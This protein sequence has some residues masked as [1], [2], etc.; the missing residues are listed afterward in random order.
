MPDKG[1]S[2]S[3]TTKQRKALARSTYS[4]HALS[5]G[6][7]E[8]AKQFTTPDGTLAFATP[9]KRRALEIRLTVLVMLAVERHW[10]DLREVDRAAVDVLFA[11]TLGPGM[12]ETWQHQRKRVGAVG[13]IPILLRCRDLQYIPEAAMKLNTA[14]TTLSADGLGGQLARDPEA[15]SFV[16]DELERVS[17]ASDPIFR[18]N[19][20]P[21]KDVTWRDIACDLLEGIDRARKA[22]QA[23][24]PASR[25]LP[26][27]LLD[28]EKTAAKPPKPAVS[29][30]EGEPAADPGPADQ[31]KPSHAKGLSRLLANPDVWNALT[32]RQRNSLRALHELGARYADSRRDAKG[33]AAK[34]EGPQ[35]NCD[36]FKQPLADLVHRGLAKSR[37][38][39]K[40]GYWLA[41]RGQKLLASVDSDVI[42]GD[43]SS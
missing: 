14:L 11:L 42:P 17:A 34:A 33:I 30:N 23:L 15:R 18:Q 28:A 22:S 10:T 9:D 40:G 8:W 39:R 1:Q 43:P 7:A 29:E 24:Q 21:E 32:D 35:A 38:G 6:V 27:D 26:A 36:G 13:G 20:P 16:W 5:W 31:F 41:D 2:K 37:I 3:P 4:F 25:R 19:C 12:R